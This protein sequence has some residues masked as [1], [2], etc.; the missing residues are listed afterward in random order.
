MK[1]TRPQAAASQGSQSPNLQGPLWRQYIMPLP[2][3]VSCTTSM[4]QLLQLLSKTLSH[5][6]QKA[7]Y[8]TSWR[9]DYLPPSV[10]SLPTHMRNASSSLPHPMQHNSQKGVGE[11][12]RPH[13]QVSLH[14]Y[15][16]TTAETSHLCTGL[17]HELS[18]STSLFSS[19]QTL[20][21]TV[22][23]KKE[24]TKTNLNCLIS[25]L[26]SNSNKELWSEFCSEIF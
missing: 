12:L 23:R 9:V 17:H 16:L 18:M 13:S 11:Y 4:K 25:S 21:N 7:T 14:R 2:P 6:P 20:L 24:K 3:S 5:G 26:P 10:S 15:H 19:F 22:K 8:D 1:V